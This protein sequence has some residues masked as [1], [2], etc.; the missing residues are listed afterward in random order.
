MSFELPIQPPARVG[1][2]I[3]GTASSGGGI[4]IPVFYPATG[5]QISTLTEDDGAAVD[6]AV[7]AARRA[8][9]TGPWPTLS[10]AKRIEVLEACRATILANVDEL[11]RLEC[12]ATGL[13]LRELRARHMVRAAYNFRFFAEYISQSAG[14]SYT[15]TEGYLTTVTREPVG[16]A[17]LIA[18]WNA[19]VALATM[20]IA[21]ALAFGN[22]CVLKPSEQTPLALA[23][24]V[25]LLQE[26]LPEGVLNLVNGRGS[27]TGAAL[28]AHPGV[29]LISFT[30]GTETGRSIMS[31]AG[32]NLVPCTMEL[33]GKS[34]NIIFAS[35]DQER[36][37]DGAL[38]GI[39]S[40]NGQQCLAGSRILLERSIFDD[41][42]EK[43]RARA[44]QVRVG[45][46]LDDA[47]EVGPLASLAHMN[48]VLSFVDAA[49]GDGGRLLTGGARRHDLG[50]GYFI[51]P[52]AVCASSNADRCAQDEIFGPFATFLPFDTAD[53]A[54]AIANDTAFGLVSY[55][56]SD[57]LP[58]VMATTPRLRSG[59]VWVN[60]PM[61]RELRAPFGGYKT[62]GVGREGGAACEAFYTEE[63]TTTLPTTPPTLRRFGAG[64]D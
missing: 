53:E 29:D 60:T 19:P 12:A 1:G 11:A 16:V 55:V 59:V 21:A 2:L 20:K 37:L 14:Q 41:F 30:G 45:D 36:A 64:A 39:F 61:M 57:D 5:A 9:D 22:T 17:A 47:T 44:E 46:P 56:W 32:R 40:N 42:T 8:F 28:V 18:P 49:R 6:H 27:V 34:A 31:A 26:V 51:A 35:A 48:R 43:F 63:K 10:V 38:Q 25:A 58:T 62:S 4:D 23:R 33:G 15:Q 52:T 24:L 54:V 50:E 13:V 3:N 7:A